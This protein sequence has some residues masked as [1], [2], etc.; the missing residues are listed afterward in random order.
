[1]FVFSIFGMS[2]FAYVKQGAM[3]DDLVNFETFG[4]SMI[5]MFTI[6]T[7]AGWD[8]LLYPIMNTPPDCDPDF[9]NP[10]TSVRGNCGSPAAGIVFLTLYII[11]SFLVVVNIQITIILEV[12]NVAAEES[13]NTLSEY[14][15]D[16]FYK[17]WERFDPQASQFIHYSELS[18]LCDALPDPLR[19][20]KPNTVN[21][22]QMDLPLVQ[23]DRVHCL[24]V[25]LALT[26]EVTRSYHLFSG[27]QID[28]DREQ[29]AQ[30]V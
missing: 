23:G 21:L 22:L 29:V 9:E 7:L 20:P 25:L 8:G 4:N 6:T 2:N 12:F 3:M 27:R 5:S 11:V 19:I 30:R 14:S 13:A 28:A 10:G 1:M 24:D 15:I 26:E 16:M 17:T 18:D